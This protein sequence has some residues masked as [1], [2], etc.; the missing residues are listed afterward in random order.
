[1]FFSS[2]SA[3]G[4][5][6]NSTTTESITVFTLPTTTSLENARVGVRF[7]Y[8]YFD[9]WN[10][11]VSTVNANNT[12]TFL[13]AI[14]DIKFNAALN[15]YSYILTAFKEDADGSIFLKTPTNFL[16]PDD[17]NPFVWRVNSEHENLYVTVNEDQYE[18]SIWPTQFF[19]LITKESLSS[20]T[21]SATFMPATGFS[22]NVDAYSY[23][24]KII[25]D[26]YSSLR[27]GA[28]FFA[29]TPKSYISKKRVN[30]DIGNNRNWIRNYY[31]PTIGKNII[32]NSFLIQV[33]VLTSTVSDIDVDDFDGFQLSYSLSSVG[34]PNDSTNNAFQR[35][36]SCIPSEELTDAGINYPYSSTA[37]TT[38]RSDIGRLYIYFNAP[39]Y[40][41]KSESIFVFYETF[42]SYNTGITIATKGGTNSFYGVSANPLVNSGIYFY[43]YYFPK[44]RSKENNDGFTIS[45]MPSSY[46]IS[47]GLSS[48]I[49][50]T[51]MIDNYFQTSYDIDV[52]QT[53]MAKRIIEETNDF[54]LSAVHLGNGI[55]YTLNQWMP[56]SGD[57]RLINNGLGNKYNFKVQLSAFT[58]AIYEERDY[59]TVLLNKKNVVIQPLVVDSNSTS[60]N[61]ETIVFPTPDEQ[62]GVKWSAFPPE[63]VTFTN[64]DGEVIQ[65][66]VLYP[67]LYEINVHNLGVDKTEI[68]LYSEEY[69]TSASTFWFPPS[70]V[71]NSVFLEVSGVVN[72]FNETGNISLS[73]LF[74]KNGNLYRVPENA[75]I[76]W[77]EL[78]ND[79]RGSLTFRATNSTNTIIDEGTVYSAPHEYSL[80]NATVS[81][82]PTFSRPKYILFNVDCNVFG[83]VAG[84][85]YQLNGNNIFLYRE[86]PSTD[87]LSISAKA[88]SSPEIINSDLQK[89]KIY[90]SNQTISLSANYSGLVTTSASIFWRIVD[91]NNNVLTANGNNTTFTLNT[92]SA[93]VGVSAL[94]AKPFEGDFK[95]YN[96]ED[97]ICFFNL[98]TLS[99]FDYIGFPENQYN[100]TT[101]A[102]DSVIDYGVCGSGYQDQIFNI[103]T[104]SNGMTSFKPC[105]TENFYFSASPGFDK[106]VWQIGTKTVEANSNKTI[107]PITYSDVSGNGNVGVS[108][109]NFIF[110]EGDLTTVYNST[111][112]NNSNVY[113]QSVTF[114][115]FPS[116]SA[117]ITLSNNLVDVSKYSSIPTLECEIDSENIN[118]SNYTFNVVLSSSEFLQYKTV[119]GNK[120]EFSKIIKINIENSD[121]IIKENSFN[122]LNVYLSGNVAV[123]V[124]GFDFCS[125]IFPLTSNI[126]Q[127]S[128]YNGPNLELYTETNLVS[129][130]ETVLFYNNSN[131]NFFSTNEEFVSFTFDNGEGTLQS[132]TSAILSTTYTTEGS[133]SPSITGVLGNGVSAISVWKDLVYVKDSKETY[134]PL[135]KREFYE[136]LAL[137]YSLND[138]RVEPN[139]WQYASVINNSF[140]KIKTN[141][142]YLSASCFVNNIMF[143]K[144]YGGYLG[145]KYG[146]FKW[147]TLYTPENLSDNF[148]SEVQSIQILEN[149]IIVCSKTIIEI[150][151]NNESPTLITSFNKI[152][153]SETFENLVKAFYVH[154]LERL[155]ILDN[156]KKII[157][158]CDYNIDAPSTINLSHYWGGVGAKEDRTKLNNPVDFC[159]DENNN[160][161]IVDRDSGLIKVYNKNLNWIENVSL[162]AFSNS[163]LPISI[164]YG[165]SRFSVTTSDGNT[166]ITDKDFNVLE[167]I[168]RTAQ[169]SILSPNDEGLVYLLNDSDLIKYTINNTYVSE[170]N[171]GVNLLNIEFDSRHLY[172]AGSNCIFKLV[173]FIQ[174][175]QI[176]NNNESL[177]GF[178]WNSIFIN[179]NEFIT[180]Y[181]FNDSMKKINDNISL[182]NSR[183]E[184]RLY[185]ELDELGNTLNQFTSAYSP[186][187]ITNYPILLATNEPVL[188]D[189][190]N[191]GLEFLYLNLDELKANADIS[192]VYPNNNFNIQW[193]WK[194]HEINNIQKP[195][196]FKNPVSWRE[197]TTNKL[198]GNTQLSS[199]SSWCTTRLGI[200]GNHSEICWNYEQVQCNSLFH[201]KWEDT[202]CDNNCGY[203]F[204]WEDLEDSCCEK[205]DFVFA[206]SI[207]V[208]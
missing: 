103:F 118:V 158:I 204:S 137:P 177:S 193:I 152:Q 56:A 163:N 26:N 92:I 164:S 124:E 192:I 122:I 146:N 98:G 131:L 161:Y 57:I 12:S 105:H 115:D 108:A 106:Y 128:A 62:Y 126:L 16:N 94:N 11:K 58:D 99:S 129:T 157:L 175:N 198:L 125:Q 145:E 153:S 69:E 65:P 72:D 132:S 71:T 67:N 8:H 102:A 48:A 135:I 134:N 191:R 13:S 40:L 199:F 140:N 110:R 188:Y 45:F 174:T 167:T 42:N 7:R 82:I 119:T 178:S 15:N 36:L 37:W 70:T 87:Y 142:D 165:F 79:Q 120:N 2:L 46:V 166:F 17:V 176:I 90:T 179:E 66:N 138:I 68:T 127:I 114:L 41:E 205:P 31:K 170:K 207:S 104:E 181:I 201:L 51:K 88:N 203:V 96:F 28:T 59:L 85:S 208:C 123:T 19:P 14:S 180:D 113:K 60:A 32:P 21:V 156:E 112:S 52:N 89:H 202:E 38:I 86:Y 183:L 84:N 5:G 186:S 27:G 130:G 172:V 64:L 49:I 33:P 169:K 4:Y 189:T 107:I 101:K 194:F 23:R 160:L 184:N 116:P 154:S 47:A 185:L 3:T 117:T 1:M 190:I 73:A 111:S 18:L 44:T 147:Q 97:Y 77:N 93:C 197:M 83:D 149:Y 155:Y 50:G 144:A 109:Y 171:L 29:E 173:D 39:F 78:A 74:N 24:Q 43:N 133:K 200:G 148:L 61:V 168:T 196:P 187:A 95:N 80:I 76:I 143:P 22:G 81:S 75:N 150:Y 141:M 162:P 34:Y 121:Y 136:G 6:N 9:S 35:S 54:S 206:D 139:S 91:S 25:D 159:L 100:P 10:N 195:S 30:F 151:S 55:T 63:N 53:K 182:L 20:F